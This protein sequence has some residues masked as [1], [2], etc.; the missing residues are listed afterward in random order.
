MEQKEQNVE[1]K[2]DAG[3]QS[4]RPI[5]AREFQ[6][7][8]FFVQSPSDSIDMARTDFNRKPIK[9]LSLLSWPT[10]Y[11]FKLSLAR[12]RQYG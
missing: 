2:K 12:D 3:G 8:S 10:E 1:G 7:C 4:S 5:L 9:I 6:E 11:I